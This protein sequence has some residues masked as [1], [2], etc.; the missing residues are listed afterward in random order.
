MIT[1]L[2]INNF[3]CLVAFEA[4][5]DSFA[6]LCGPN[7]AGKSSVFDALRLLRNLATGDASLGGTGESDIPR[8]DFTEWLDS[9][10]QEFELGLSVD[11][12]VFEYV[13][14]IE[15]TNDN[16]KPRVI[17]EKGLCDGQPL[18]ERNLDGVRFLRADGSQAFFPLDW[19]QAAL[20]AI[21]PRGS[22]DKLSLLQEEIAKLL[23]LR[24]NPRSMEPE[25]KGELRHPD[26]SMINLTSQSDH[27]ISV[28]SAP[29]SMQ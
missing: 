18:F 12:R 29:A 13:V 16:E 11:G 15:Q 25:S 4:K 21:Q 19:R 24:P 17:H 3:R 14:H 20:S 5:F 7:G 8:L 9:R 1:R 27:T 26:L 6:V 2:Y 28:V 10:V 23:I 22:L